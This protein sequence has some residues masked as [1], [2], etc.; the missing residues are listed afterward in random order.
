MNF[1]YI[2]LEQIF[3]IPNFFINDKCLAKNFVR[4]VEKEKD[5]SVQINL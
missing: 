3:Y 2:C 1:L 5:K 4:I